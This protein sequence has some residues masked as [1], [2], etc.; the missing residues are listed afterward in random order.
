MFSRVV[1]NYLHQV[2]TGAL[3]QVHD[4]LLSAK[5]KS[6]LVLLANSNVDVQ[7][8]DGS[9]TPLNVVTT[10]A[11]NF[12][13]PLSTVEELL[14]NVPAADSQLIDVDIS[15]PGFSRRSSPNAS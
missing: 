4:R 6:R 1:C 8:Y 2:R 7:V 10:S 14:R 9:S 11:C 5:V 12:P 15:A 13:I 3:V